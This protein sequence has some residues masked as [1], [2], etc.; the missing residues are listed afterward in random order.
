MIRV[1]VDGSVERMMLPGDT[2]LV[3]PLG[4]VTAVSSSGPFCIIDPET[5][6]LIKRPFPYPEGDA[7]VIGP[8]CFVAND[9]SVLS[10]RGVNY[11]PQRE[12]VEERLPVIT[13]PVLYRSRTAAY[14]VPAI[15]TATTE[16]LNLGAVE[17]GLIPALSSPRH[18]HLTVLSPGLPVVGQNASLEALG[19]PPQVRELPPGARSFNLAG[20][21]QEWDVPYFDPKGLPVSVAPRVALAGNEL[22]Q[23]PGSWT[24]P[25]GLRG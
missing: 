20:T 14:T 19:D 8:E 16:S 18:V 15:V 22:E 23:M 3:E 21:Y 11:V 13:D 25:G 6:H 24:W 5:A 1:R 2:L 10:W 7:T 12:P 9:G 17:A 4:D